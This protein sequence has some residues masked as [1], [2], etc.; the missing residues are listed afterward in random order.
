MIDERDHGHQ[1][2]Y[3]DQ[4]AADVQDKEGDDPANRQ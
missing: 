3:V 4:E 2:D 1:K